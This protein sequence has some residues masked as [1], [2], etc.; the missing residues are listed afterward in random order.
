LPAA[1]FPHRKISFLFRFISLAARG[2]GR[3]APD[4]ILGRQAIGNALNMA[5]LN[6]KGDGNAVRL[7]ISAHASS[8]ATMIPA[9]RLP[10]RDATHV[11]AA[12]VAP[13]QRRNAQDPMRTCERSGTFPKIGDGID[14]RAEQFDAY[15][16]R[17][18]E[19]HSKHDRQQCGCRGSM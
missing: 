3:R 15:D 8:S 5:I 17:Q 6:H 2:A 4:R 9:S 7:K 11:A 12:A 18:R 1:I 16:E 19:R 10:T 13:R 14:G